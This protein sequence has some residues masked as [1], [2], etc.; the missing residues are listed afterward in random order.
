MAGRPLQ[1]FLRM[2]MIIRAFTEEDASVLDEVAKAAFAEYACYFENWPAYY[3]VWSRMSELHDIGRLLVADME[4]MVVGGVCCIGPG[5]CEIAPGYPRPQWF[6]KEWAI[7]RS[8]VV[9]PEHRGHGIGKSL[10]GACISLAQ[11]DGCETV[12]LQSAPFMTDAVAMYQHMGFQNIKTIGSKD[13]VTWHLYC[14]D[15]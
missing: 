1:G 12:A 15:L 13:G 6:D 7:I 14:L 3:D 2:S 5:T 11:N 10:M 9:H 8:L 4:G